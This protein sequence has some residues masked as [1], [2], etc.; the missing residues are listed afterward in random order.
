MRAATPDHAGQGSCDLRAI[1]S[2]ASFSCRLALQSGVPASKIQQSCLAVVSVTIEQCVPS[3]SIV[4]SIQARV[5]QLMF[6][7][8]RRRKYPRICE[9]RASQRRC[10][11]P[12]SLH[13]RAVRTLC[14]TSF[15]LNRLVLARVASS[16][17][18]ATKPPRG[19]PSHRRTGGRRRA[20]AEPAETGMRK[21][22]FRKL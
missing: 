6:T 7:A 4:S 9:S 3:L 16:Q 17:N 20:E 19:A 10:S 22:Q 2:L 11:R 14:L 21:P 13:Q 8:L 15:T 12:S 18:F 1:D 5:F